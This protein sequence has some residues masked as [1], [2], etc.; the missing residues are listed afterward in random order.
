MEEKNPKHNSPHQHTSTPPKSTAPSMASLDIKP[1]RNNYA[2]ACAMLAST[3]W[4]LCGYDVAVMS[5]A[6]LFIKKDLK[7]TDTQI[8]ILAGVINLF[9]LLGRWR[10]G[11]P[12]TGSGGATPSCWRPPSSLRGR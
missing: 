12:R 7:V 9:S 3:T 6:Q 1:R 11:A 5:G 2:L 4:I 10:R 8:E